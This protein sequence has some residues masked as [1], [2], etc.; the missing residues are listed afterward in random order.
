MWTTHW[1]MSKTSTA[2]FIAERYLFSK[3]KHTAIN[4]ISGI[5][6][7]GVVV[8]S[9]ALVCVMSVFN[10]FQELMADLFTEF[11]PELRITL[12]DKRPFGAKDAHVKALEQLDD[13][14]VLTP[15]LEDKA[16]V[17]RGGKQ[18]VVTLKGVADNFSEQHHLS[19]ILYGEG[20]PTLHVDVLE[21]GILGIGLCGQLGLG[22]S[23]DEPLTIYAPKKGEQ[24]NMANPM[25]SFTKDELYSPGV[26]FMVHQNQYDNNYILCSLGFAQRLFSRENQYSALE[27]KLRDGGRRSAV[28]SVLKGT[29]FVVEDLYEQQ[30]D[31]FRIM[32]V[33]KLVAYLFL[34]FILLVASL[35]IIGSLTMLIIDKKDDILTLRNIGFPLA[36]R[37]NIFL[38]VGWTIVAVGCLIGLFLGYVLCVLQDLFGLIKMGNGDGAYIVDAYPVSLHAMDFLAVLLTVTL[39]GGTAV[40]SVIRFTSISA[41]SP[42][43]SEARDEN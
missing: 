16:L 4:I 8:G 20:S 13:V 31:V 37:R 21:Y 10:G 22:A 24:V 11:D 35:N 38:Y 28:E 39:L 34:C 32:Q 18:T 43:K 14:A 29:D 17:V 26:V 40:Y 9:M 5:S 12:S 19:K 15:V 33:E 2:F 1:I 3:K 27:V 25:S 30:S 42:R 41:L 23:F 6:M 36:V 7:L